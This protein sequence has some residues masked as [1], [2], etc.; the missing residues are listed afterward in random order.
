MLINNRYTIMEN[1]QEKLLERSDFLIKKLE[2]RD[3]VY[4]KILQQK[5]EAIV[6]EAE[7][8]KVVDAVEDKVRNT[9]CASPDVGEASGL[10]A[11][12]VI[13]QVKDAVKD[14]VVEQAKQTPFVLEHTHTHVMSHE[15][16]KYADEKVKDIIYFLAC[17]CVVLVAV[18]VGSLAWYYNSEHYWGSQYIEI[19]HSQYLTDDEKR[20]LREDI[21]AA[22]ALPKEYET[23]EA[24]VKA[25]IR[26]NKAV[27]IG[28]FACTFFGKGKW[29]FFRKVKCT[30]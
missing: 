21:Y 30:S 10:I 14:A 6:P 5:Q 9:Q 15:L 29:T 23:N 13:A 4:A 12:G 1:D 3:A 17:L 19:A 24:Y 27:V 20:A 22:D 28:N 25:K 26:Q 16:V 18:I 2:E 8:Q 7:V 11:K